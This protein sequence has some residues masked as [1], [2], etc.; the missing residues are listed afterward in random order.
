MRRNLPNC[1]KCGARVT[2]D[3]DF[4]PKCGTALKP[5]PTPLAP[6]APTKPPAPPYREEKYEKREKAEKK[7]KR[8]K[9][10]KTEKHEKYERRELSYLAPLVGG[11]ILICLGLMFYVTTQLPTFPPQILVALFFIIIGV[12]IIVAG[13]YAVTT[14]TRRSPRP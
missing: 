14:V 7:E 9:G 5:A 4:C 6:A 3:Y 13:V 12:M 10:E 8:E 2:E 11:L 1:P